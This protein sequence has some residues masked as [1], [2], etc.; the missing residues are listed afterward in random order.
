MENFENRR[1]YPRIPVSIGF[2]CNISGISPEFFYSTSIFDYSE[3][4]M[5]ILWE[6]CNPCTGYLKGK[7]DPKCIFSPYNYHTQGTDELI[8]HIELD[9]Y[10][11]DLDFKGK[12]IYTLKESDGIERIGIVFTDITDTTIGFMKQVF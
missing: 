3:G 2:K 1:K 4:G 12:A 10:D 11:F 9:N 8:F 5:C 6:F 7:I